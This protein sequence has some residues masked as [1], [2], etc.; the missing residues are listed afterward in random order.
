MS[1]TVPPIPPPLGTSSGNS[2]INVPA[3]NK[4]DFTS[5]KVRFLVFLDGLKPYLLKTLEDGPFV[6]MSS[7]STSKNPL[8]KR[9]NQWS[10]AESRLAN[11]DKRLKNIIISCLPN[12]VMKSVIKCKTAKQMWNDLILA[13]KGPSDTRDT[14]I[15]SLRL[16][17][18]A[19]KSL[20]GE[21][22]NGTF[23]ILKCLLNDLEYNG[24][25]IPQ[26]E[27][28][29]SKALISNNHFQDID[30]DVEEDQ[31]TSNKFMADLN[32]EY[33]ERALLANQKR[34][35]KRSG[36][37]G[38]ARKL[39]DK[40][41][42]TCF[43]YGKT[44]H[45][46]KDYPSNKTSTPSYPSSN[47]S[48]NKPKPYTPPFNQTSSRNTEYVSS[49]DEGTTKIRAFMAIAEDEPSV[50]KANARYGQ[51][52]DITMKKTC[53]KVTLDQLLSEQIPGNIVKALGGRGK[54]KDN[55]SLKEVIFTKADESS[56]MS[57]PKI[58]SDFESKCETQE[59][60]PPF[61]KLIGATLA[62]TLDSLISL[63][64][65][66]L[67]MVDLTL[68]TSILKKT[69]P[70]SVK[71]SPGYV[72]KRKTKNKSLVVSESYTDKKA[73][74]SVEQLLL[75]LMEEFST[76]GSTDHLTK[77][78]LEHAA[79]KKTLIKLKAQSPLN[80]T[81]NKAPII[82]KPF[83][84]C[85]Y[86]GFNDHYFDNCEYYPG[87]EDYLKRSVWYLDSGYSRHMTRI[88]QYLHRYSKESG[89]KVVFGDDSLEDTEGYGLVNCNGITFTKGTIFNQNDEVILISLR[90]RDVYV[91]DMSSFNKESN[92]CFFAKASPS[93][94]WRW[95]KR[96]SYLN[97][98]NINN[99]A[100]HNLVS[101]LPSLTFSKDKNYSACEKGKHHR[102]SFKIKR[103]F[104][105]NKS[106]HLLH[107][108]LFKL[109]KPQTINH[110]KYT[111]VIID[112]YSRKMEN[113][114]EVRVKEL[115]SDNGT[116]F[117]NHKLEEFCDEKVISQNF[118]S[119]Y[120]FKQ[121]G[122]AERK[123]KT[124]I[125]AARTMLNSVKLLKQFWGEAVNTACYTQNRSII[126]K[127]HGKTAY[128][129]FKGR[130]PD[131]SYFNVFGCPMYFHNHR[132][133]FGK[134]DEKADDGFFLGYSPVDKAF[135]VFN[136][137]RQEMEEIVHV[138]FSEDDEAI[139]QSNIKGDAI[140]FNENR[141]FLDDEFLEPRS[142]VTQ[143][144]ANIEYFPYIPSYENTTPT[145]SPI[146]QDSVSP[147]E[148]LEF[149]NADD[150]PAFSEHDNFESGD[151]LKP[152]EIQDNHIELVNIIGEPLAGIT[153]RSR[154][155]DSEAAS[156]HECLYVNFLSEM[157]PKKLIEALEEEGWIIAMQ[158]ELNQFERNKVWTLVPKPHG[159]LLRVIIS[160]KG[161]I[162]K[163]PLH[164]LQDWK[165]SG[166]FL[167][168]QPTWVYGVSEGCEKFIF[169]SKNFKGG[170]FKGISLCQGKYIKDLLKKYDLADSALV[171]CPMLP[172][173]NLGLDESGVFVNETLF[174]G[175]IGSLMYLT[176]SRPDIQFS[177]CLCAKYQANPKESHLVAVKNNFRYLKGTLNLGLWYPKGSGFD[178]KAYSDSD[179]VGCNL[180]RKSI[181]GG[182]QIL[183]GNNTVPLPPKE[184]VGPVTQPKAPTDLK[185]K[186]KKIPLSSNPKSSYKV[187][188]ILLKTQVIKTQHAEEIVATADATKSLDTSESAEEQAN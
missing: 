164:L 186:K 130:S 111:L 18:N 11:Q 71:V 149:T 106:L 125:E 86:Y 9:Q 31:R 161:L 32:V 172:S 90:R 148:P 27:A 26:A 117:R 65:L 33:H 108:D 135:R 69:R 43:T 82:Q 99:L 154:V 30:S 183:G 20:E 17:F 147:K 102:A 131:I 89:P 121:N 53:S 178:L 77:E 74:S 155:K 46:Q 34:F 187:R 66:T 25:I 19:F 95:H 133:H 112:E 28:S 84:D 136:I 175:M 182:C 10:N 166:S 185:P 35:Y 140:N 37:V 13:H 174:K 73:D 85:K 87:C 12:D 2:I 3:F 44:D 114:N 105:I 62:G 129:V 47:N 15:A 97:F 107:M 23:T 137:R 151:N 56:S 115:R 7:L 79:V 146:L 179:Y 150:H 67:N 57:I 169:E 68:D 40:S 177:T 101:V 113:L 76:C 58:T 158:E 39:I 8:T 128:D 14:K 93:V 181:S 70:T 81:P 91:I 173:N 127:R 103:S 55:I 24:V 109:V 52:V 167:L 162:M 118:S 163:K 4:E 143:C 96:L 48:F 145:D 72:I 142:K 94:N 176:A 123:N 116:E 60:L 45:F 132:D 188:V 83:K 59:P 119:P 41:K 38:S 64:D 51:W 16:K 92:A 110:N 138:T 78:H 171:K 122:V 126:V 100:K 36:R 5:W 184:T 75:T 170:D 6:P 139:S 22:V 160:R 152:A 134:F 29:S 63:S 141:S 61:P 124:L 21:K 88:K 49:K 180:D 156:A 165:P 168:M 1:G 120:T 104:S 50:G 144:S 54:R 153:T 159:W 42:E 98:K 80:P 157:E